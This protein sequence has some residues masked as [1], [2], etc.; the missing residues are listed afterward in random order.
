M[1]SEIKKKATG[2]PTRH[3]GPSTPRVAGLKSNGRASESAGYIEEFKGFSKETFEF[4]DQLYKHNSV[5]WFRKHRP[6]YEQ[7]LL[8]PARLFVTSIGP[9]IK[10]INPV[11][12][13]EPKFNRTLVRINRDMRFAK[14][15]YKDFML[16]RF[17]KSKWDSEL[18]L[19]IDRN[20]MELGTFI[21][22]EKVDGR[23][24]FEENVSSYGQAFLDACRK[25]RIGSEFSAYELHYGTEP[26]SESFKPKRDHL[27]F[28]GVNHIIFGKELEKFD[29]VAS[30]K[31]L[32][33]L[34]MKTFNRL[35]PLYIFSTSDN[36]VADLEAY[37]SRIGLLKISS[38]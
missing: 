34:A 9:F 16:I 2:T 26:I 25:Y 17:G 32:L 15:P 7:F 24:R 38:K 21:N 4:L 36:P 35:Y 31:R 20:G 14:K 3:V 13:T 6:E 30:S 37:T 5:T 12:D 22:N 27:K 23:R 10:F 1:K 28:K 11:L 19:Y 33:A 18:F 29:P 8:N